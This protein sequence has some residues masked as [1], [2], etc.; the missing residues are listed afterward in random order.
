MKNLSAILCFLFGGLTGAVLLG[1]L[2]RIC[3]FAG[4]ITD[5]FAHLKLLG[6][7]AV[8]FGGILGAVTV[9][10]LASGFVLLSNGRG[11]E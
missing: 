11:R 9:V 4:G 8:V 1:W 3:Y 7:E 5:G 2:G 6:Y 10:L